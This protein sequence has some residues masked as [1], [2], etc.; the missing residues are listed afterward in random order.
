[1]HVAVADDDGGR[2]EATSAVPVA[3]VAPELKVQA[4]S[5]KPGAPVKLTG[6]ISD[7]GVRDGQTVTI[8]WG[9]GELQT[10]TLEPG[11]RVFDA[12]RTLASSGTITITAEVSD[13]DGARDQAAVTVSQ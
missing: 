3:N 9:A 7:P 13:D 4:E 11:T 12:E 10:I 8:D 6:I 1:M 5:D 2:G